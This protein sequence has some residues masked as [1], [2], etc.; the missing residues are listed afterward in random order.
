M[1]QT[2]VAEEEL[3]VAEEELVVGLH[4]FFFQF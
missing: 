3:V 1:M 2:S 4:F